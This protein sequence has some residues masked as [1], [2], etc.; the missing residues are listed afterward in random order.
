MGN[1]NGGSLS[2]HTMEKVRSMELKK[3]ATEYTETGETDGRISVP[4]FFRAVYAE[5]GRE[6]PYD[7][8]STAFY[9]MDM[10]IDGESLG[11]QQ[12]ADKRRHALFTMKDWKRG[13]SEYNVRTR[14]LDN[15]RSNDRLNP[16]IV[17][18]P[19]DEHE[20]ATL[21]AIAQRY[22]NVYIYPSKDNGYVIVPSKRFIT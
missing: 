21:I 16:Y 7:L 18:H 12:R 10:P 14:S 19:Q 1:E 5:M 20:K 17:I 6:I 13:N 9:D 3:R 2:E 4:G 22:D 8:F 11:S 15:N